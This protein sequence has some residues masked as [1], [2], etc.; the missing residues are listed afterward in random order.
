MAEARPI[1]VDLFQDR[2]LV[3]R[4]LNLPEAGRHKIVV[5]GLS[6][7]IRE[8]AVSFVSD[9][10][11]IVEDV[12]VERIY[13]DEDEAVTE[14]IAK[15][16]KEREL[17]AH[18]HLTNETAA[19]RA[20]EAASRA[21]AGLQTAR[22][23]T[24]RALAT[25]D[26]PSAW[27]DGLQAL[28]HTVT[29]ATIRKTEA[30]IAQARTAAELAQLDNRLQTAKS[31][32]KRIVSSLTLSA[33]VEQP[34]DLEIRYVLPAAVWRPVH[35]ATLT[36]GKVAWEVGAM[37]WN[38][39]GEDWRDVEVVCSTARPGDHANPPPLTDDIVRSQRRGDV[40]VEVR[41]E[42]IDSARSGEKRV[43]EIPGV[44]DGGEPRTFTAAA[45][46]TLISNGQPVHVPLDR[47]EDHA[48]VA[49]EA[50][51]ERASEVVLRS[52]QRNT[53]TR[54]ILAGPVFLFRG[55]MAVGTGEVSLVPAGEPFPMGWGS[56]DGIR[57]VRRRDHDVEST[58]IT[59]HKTHTFDIELRVVHL[60][61][62]PVQIHLKERIPV[63]EIKEVK[64]SKPKSSPAF[65]SGPDRDGLCTWTLS[66][67]PGEDRKLKYSYELEA[68]AKVR[69]PF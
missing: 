48:E 8:R 32:R 13:L 61:D 33:L 38:A 52:I 9:G 40:V 50:H 60:G 7:L 67:K 54:P 65:T 24:D 22:D 49:W 1:R 41:E 5:E 36:E 59:G 30:D 35:R 47:W 68:P 62:E 17:L 26:D 57:L 2:C 18:R 25:H 21:V 20:R 31:G 63:S 37:V 12:S 55:D 15:L 39:T 64:V 34:G 11:I 28:G 43:D 69:L 10:G 58:L 46:V 42:V 6:P 44:D 51:P 19:V 29:D 23:Y 45:P 53:S 66:L 27:L 14:V 3:V 16:D 56:H 4:R